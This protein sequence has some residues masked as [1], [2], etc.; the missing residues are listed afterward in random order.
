[1]AAVAADA[2]TK[3]AHP[4]KKTT[5]SNMP[6]VSSQSERPKLEP[7]ANFDPSLL[8]ALD[9]IDLDA[10]EDLFSPDKLAA[11]ATAGDNKISFEDA[12]TQGIIGDVDQ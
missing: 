5:T 3:V 9:K 8:D 12:L 4:H 1:M 7:I 6:V 10:A 11:N 2:T